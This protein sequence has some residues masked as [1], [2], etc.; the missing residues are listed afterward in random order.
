MLLRTIKAFLVTAAMSCLLACDP[1]KDGSDGDI[2][3]VDGLELYDLYYVDT[4]ESIRI[5]H[6]GDGAALVSNLG[7]PCY[8]HRPCSRHSTRCVET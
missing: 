5:F 1:C 3:D 8:A 6:D 7:I 4:G 2:V